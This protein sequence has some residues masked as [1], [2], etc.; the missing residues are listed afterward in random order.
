MLISAFDIH[1]S[2]NEYTNETILKTFY[3]DKRWILLVALHS[4]AMHRFFTRS[5][6]VSQ[7]TAVRQ[8]VLLHTAKSH[9]TV[10]Q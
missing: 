8:A 3:C 9:S 6:N 7:I 1:L 4:S 5:V 10:T 2:A